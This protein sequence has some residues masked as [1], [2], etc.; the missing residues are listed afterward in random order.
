M[1]PLP[2][3]WPHPTPEYQDLA[4]LI[5]PNCGPHCPRWKWLEQFEFSLSG[6]SFTQV[7]AFLVKHF[8][9]RKLPFRSFKKYISPI[10]R[11]PSLL[12]LFLFKP[13]DTHTCKCVSILVRYILSCSNWPWISQIKQNED[14]GYNL[15]FI[16]TKGCI[17]A[18]GNNSILHQ[19]P[20]DLAKK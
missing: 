12:S 4:N 7:L 20:Y 3:M 17:R 19:Y 13:R 2:L 15:T 1:D 5:A 8:L 18:K 9:S 16:N 14:Q 11:H 10:Q 6:V